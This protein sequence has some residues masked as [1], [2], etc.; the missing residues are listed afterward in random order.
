MP[1]NIEAKDLKEAF[2]YEPD[3]G[4]LRWGVR[5][6]NCIHA[7]DRAGMLG[8]NGYRKVRFK[9]RTLLEHRVIY[10]LVNGFWPVEEIDHL[11]GVRSDNRICNLRQVSTQVNRQNQ[12]RAHRSSS[13]GFLGVRVYKKKFAAVITVDGKACRLGTYSTPEQ[14]HAVYLEAK[15]RHHA[16]C[17]I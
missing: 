4:V 10:A 15:R 7:G 12:R 1:A 9:G 11:N 3:T 5:A 16:G 17:T 6:A 2:T 8:A 13:H 14:A